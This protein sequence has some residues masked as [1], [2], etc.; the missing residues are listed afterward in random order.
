MNLSK[1]LKIVVALTFLALS[2]AVANEA[3]NFILCPK[4]KSLGVAD[5][6]LYHEDTKVLDL[7]VFHFKGPAHIINFVV[8]K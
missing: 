2:G 4:C 6:V 7:T 3:P 5:R 8:K 1:S